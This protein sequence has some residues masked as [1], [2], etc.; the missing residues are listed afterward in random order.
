[1]GRSGRGGGRRFAR[2]GLFCGVDARLAAAEA[3]VR[4]CKNQVADQ[5][6]AG[7]RKAEQLRAQLADASAEWA[8]ERQQ[9]HTR[10]TAA[11]DAVE[12]QQQ[13]VDDAQVRIVVLETG[14]CALWFDV[15]FVAVAWLLGCVC[16]CLFACVLAGPC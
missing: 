5:V 4:Q 6:Q 10:M 11:Q 9:L 15:E 16:A 3:T 14:S 12:R 8:R 13:D 2:G 7:K 1:M